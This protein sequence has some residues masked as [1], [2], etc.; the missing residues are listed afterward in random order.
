M[1]LQ[2]LLLLLL[3]G[4]EDGCSVKRPHLSGLS[5]EQA[6]TNRPTF[7]RNN[8]KQLVERNDTKR[9]E[10]RRESTWITITKHDHLPAK[11]RPNYN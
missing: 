7:Q 6:E 11:F 8:L 2:L 9:D 5:V 10:K 4:R 1:L 3:F